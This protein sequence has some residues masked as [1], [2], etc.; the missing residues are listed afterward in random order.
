MLRSLRIRS[1]LI[2]IVVAPIVALSVL[3]ALGLRQRTND[4]RQANDVR[5]Y[6]RLADAVR[7][8]IKNLASER[9]LAIRLVAGGSADPVG[10]QLAEARTKVDQSVIELTNAVKRVGGLSATLSRALAAAKNDLAG[11][12]DR[13]T[14]IDAG[15][16]TTDQIIDGYSTAIRDLFEY[17]EE[18]PAD[19]S[20]RDVNMRRLAAAMMELDA[21][22]ESY[23]RIREVTDVALAKG[24]V[25]VANYGEIRAQLQR[26]ADQAV[27]FRDDANPAEAAQLAG[28]QTGQAA[29]A[30]NALE[31]DIVTAGSDAKLRGNAPDYFTSATARIDALGRLEDRTA[32]ALFERATNQAD[33]AS[34]AQRNYLLGTLGALALAIALAALVARSLTKPVRQLTTSATRIAN[35]ELPDLVQAI[36]TQQQP[37][38]PTFAPI[39]VRSRDEIGELAAAFNTVHHVAVSTAIEQASLRRSVSDMFVNLG[40]RNQSLIS[41][42][43]E[44]IDTLE[45]TERDPDVLE[46]LFALDHLATRMRR[47]AENLLVLAGEEPPRKWGQLVPLVD[48]IRAAV[49]EV[50]DYTRVDVL[51]DDELFLAGHAA[52]DVAHLV[53]ELVE[54]ATN[55]SAPNTRVRIRV[56]RTS[57]R[58]L[59]SVVDQGIGMTEADLLAANERLADPPEADLT[60]TNRVGFFVIGR[61]A[62]RSGTAVRLGRSA[63][64]GTIAQLALPPSL[65]SSSL[66][67]QPSSALSPTGT[68]PL[69]DSPQS[70]RDRLLGALR[71]QPARP[72]DQSPLTRDDAAVPAAIAA[73]GVA[74]PAVAFA[75]AEPDGVELLAPPRASEPAPPEPTPPDWTPAPTP[76]STPT[77]LPTPTP[78]ATSTWAPPTGALLPPTTSEVLGGNNA[79]ADPAPDHDRAANNERRIAADSFAALL[80]RSHVDST[81]RAAEA[82]NGNGSSP[83]PTD[84]PLE[85]APTARVTSTGLP[86][87]QAG[88]HRRTTAPSI[89]QETDADVDADTSAPRSA[90][91]VRSM[92]TRF[93][94]GVQRGRD[95]PD[96]T[97]S[98]TPEDG[99]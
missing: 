74:T 19:R 42:Q 5:R 1:K 8:A 50:E 9:G 12:G 35:E 93:R 49:S 54:N 60:L 28:L 53:A 67:E 77:P 55:F 84:A 36:S 94:G 91:E 88:A 52:S 14:A 3:A 66:A 81:D 6:A 83:A 56:E 96:P 22:S 41:R 26:I 87:R 10:P 90:D 34:S 40:R 95:L 18:L 23:A 11:L 70:A 61:L 31:N 51:A 17:L 44:L 25:T 27:R 32:A 57:D 63:T 13:R 24:S 7:P 98:A 71:S 4:G 68:G 39:K 15:T 79:D 99:S 69:G 73:P 2:A 58:Y 80:G 16:T 43:L 65:V 76:A 62:Y 64:G 21:T 89:A 33:D 29:T 85:P 92:L 45:S 30:A 97:T 46:N 59:I 37:V 75:P 47:N 86:V 48:V 82:V 72:S 78:T 38:S 20:L